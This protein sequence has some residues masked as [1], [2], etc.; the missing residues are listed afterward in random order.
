MSSVLVDTSAWIELLRRGEGE[1]A[2][3]VAQLV[4]HDQAFLTGP[5]LAELVQGTKSKKEAK[6]LTDLLSVLPFVEVERPDWQAAGDELRQ[7][8]SRGVTLPLTDAVIAAVAR[9]RRLAV[10]TL[11]KHFASLRVDRVES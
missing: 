6:R 7:L 1:I 4:E 10:L 9:R 3:L 2:A 5:V 11:D 8:R